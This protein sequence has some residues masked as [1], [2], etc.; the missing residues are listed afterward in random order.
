M[1]HILLT[2]PP[3]RLALEQV[4]APLDPSTRFV[5]HGTIVAPISKAEALRYTRRAKVMEPQVNFTP[6]STPQTGECLKLS[7]ESKLCAMNEIIVA[8]QGLPPCI[9]N[10]LYRMFVSPVGYR[11]AN[12]LR[13]NVAAYLNKKS[14]CP[15]PK[16][17]VDSCV[18][19]TLCWLM[20]NKAELCSELYNVWTKG[21]SP[22]NCSKA[23]LQTTKSGIPLCPSLN[24]EC[25]EVRNP[26][27]LFKKTLVVQ[28][29]VRKRKLDVD[30]EF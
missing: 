13:F 1:E 4:C 27:V 8:Y 7:Y 16:S 2:S 21:M 22:F 29:L 14:R 19:K 5:R 3:Y 24:G 15:C 9:A 28:P 26:M 20:D 11:E 12:S 6:N 30:E 10:G 25:G 23:K 18:Y 17:S